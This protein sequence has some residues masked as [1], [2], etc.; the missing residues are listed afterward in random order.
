MGVGASGRGEVMGWGRALRGLRQPSAEGW[1]RR[2]ERRG[3]GEGRGEPGGLSLGCGR[4]GEQLPS[5]EPFVGSAQEWVVKPQRA[6]AGSGEPGAFP[7]A[8]LGT[9][10]DGN[11]AAPAGPLAQL[12]VVPHEAGVLGFCRGRGLAWSRF[13]G[14]A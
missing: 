14:A 6:G 9:V 13:V 7:A 11:A 10:S 12:W 1:S 2:G 8:S 3:E 5:G 4:P